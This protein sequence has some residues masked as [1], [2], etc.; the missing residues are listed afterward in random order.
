MLNLDRLLKETR[1][2]VPRSDI[3]GDNA[4]LMKP[5]D[6][7]RVRPDDWESVSGAAILA[8]A[9]RKHKTTVLI[10]CGLGALAGLLIQAPRTPIFRSTVSLAVE[11]QNDDY[12]YNKDVNPN[13][14]LG[15]SYPDIEMAT[16]VKVLGTRALLNRV[17][18]KLNLDEAVHINLPEE[19]I[20]AWRKALRLPVAPPANRETLL[21][22]TAQSVQIKPIRSTRA[23]DIS[24]DSPDPALAATFANAM[25]SE[26][27]EQSL[28]IRWESARHT[29][30][31]LTGQLDGMKLKLQ[32]S[33]EQL[34]AYATAMNLIPTGD[35]N[36]DTMANDK[37]RQLQNQL[38]EAQ[39]DLASKQSRYELAV[40]NP[41][42]SLGQVLDDPSLRNY[43]A[44]LADLRRE[45]AQLSSTLTPAHY[46]VQEVQS[47]ISELETT[48]NSARNNVVERIHN[49]FQEATR[50]EQLLSSAL[51]RQ[52][53]VVTDQSGKIVHYDILRHDVD[54]NRQLY[55]S[56][57]QRVKET[58]ISSALRASN[59]QVI[60]QAETSSAPI[61]PNLPLG[62]GLGLMTGLVLGIGL[63]LV[64]DQINPCIERPGDA[65]FYLNTPELGCI[66]SWSLDRR[67]GEAFRKK[68]MRLANFSRIAGAVQPGAP[69]AYSTVAESF[70]LLLTS[71]LFVGRRH[72]VQVLVVTSP[73]PSEGKSTVVSNLAVA[74]AETGRRVLVIDSDM[75]RPRLH[76]I[77]GVANDCGLG[78]LLSEATPLDG[79]SLMRAI[80]PTEI[81]GVSVIPFGDADG[82]SSANLMHSLRLPELVDLARECF[83]VVLIDTPPM[84]YM[85]DSRIVGSLADGVLLVVRARQTLRESAVKA[86]RQ[87][88]EDGVPFLG[89][90]L[91][92]WNPRLA[93]Y[94]SAQEYAGYYDK[95]R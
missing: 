56:L 39:N 54:S 25:A 52:S 2:A 85:A 94:Y 83:D 75:A 50:R 33:E 40:T 4:R 15:A 12:F 35:S 63:V 73:N 22:Q 17:I 51:A 87:L 43:D 34:T 41:P 78:E 47:Q 53:T 8:R 1:V 93:G 29:S 44:K 79:H 18:E 37:L 28:D 58:G 66:P 16:Q 92:D 14:G 32:K 71:I 31:W 59:I 20:S 57:L 42:D 61:S 19:R 11:P 26:Y 49:D 21:R 77:L 84:L 46:K 23:I 65:A 62:A 88:A 74:Y 72:A 60:D 13:S 48:R 68:P 69:K 6:P 27:I 81:P 91:N 82:A 80:H 24:C 70:R 86:G 7:L 3:A 36:K 9:I 90:A 55:E 38:L 76:Q 67:R 45:L 10:A 5:Q 64:R 95:D 30:E 89:V